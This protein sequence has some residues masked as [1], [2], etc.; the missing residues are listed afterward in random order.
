MTHDGEDPRRTAEDTYRRGERLQA[1]F[2]IRL[3]Q[4]SR[5]PAYAKQYPIRGTILQAVFFDLLLSPL[6]IIAVFFGLTVWAIIGMFMVIGVAFFILM[7][8][9]NLVVHRHG[10][11]WLDAPN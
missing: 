2:K 3:P 10:E 9:Y 11:P 8:R 7:L 4:F 1:R 5:L 6:G